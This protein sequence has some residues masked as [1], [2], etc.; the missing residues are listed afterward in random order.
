MKEFKVY[1]EI[2]GKKMMA[3]IEAN[4]AAEAKRKVLD[5]VIFHKVVEQNDDGDDMV[6]HLKSL[7]GLT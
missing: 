2:Y 4:S 3:V 7:F 1:F 5:K 6:N